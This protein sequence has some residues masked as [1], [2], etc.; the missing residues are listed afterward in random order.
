MVIRRQP[1]ST[2]RPQRRCGD[3]RLPT[4]E[5]LASLGPLLCL[6]RSRDTL[7]SGWRRAVR[8]EY[9]ARLDS[10]GLRECIRFHAADDEC[11]WRLYSLPEDDFLAWDRLI[12]MVPA[13]PDEDA[14]PGLAERL[15]R[16]LADALLGRRWRASLLRIHAFQGRDGCEQRCLAVS[17]PMVSSFSRTVAYQ[18]ARAEGADLPASEVVLA[19]QGGAGAGRYASAHARPDVL[20]PITSGVPS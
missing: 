10:D 4:I 19:S 1:P 3:G 2:H 12:A 16:D 6:S 8:C 7:L 18:I 11:C 13:R 15:W 9:G 14:L 5:T 17:H 20:S